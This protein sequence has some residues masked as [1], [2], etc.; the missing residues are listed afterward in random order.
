MFWQQGHAVFIAFC[1]AHEDRMLTKVDVFDTQAQAF[2]QAQA[3]AVEEL[4]LE[5]E[6]GVVDV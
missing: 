6:G 2:K 1:I 3:G 4:G 5:P